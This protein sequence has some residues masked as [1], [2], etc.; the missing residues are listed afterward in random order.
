MGSEGRGKLLVGRVET[1]LLN[2]SSS[3]YPQF[4]PDLRG[5]SSEKPF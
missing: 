2:F 4:S 1:S 3:S 5:H